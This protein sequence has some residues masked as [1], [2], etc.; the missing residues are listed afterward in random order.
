M[1]VGSEREEGQQNNKT[2]RARFDSFRV[3]R[4]VTRFVGVGQDPE[5]KTC[6]ESL[7]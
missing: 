1:R 7:R 2:Y 6:E 3:L 5:R 4:E